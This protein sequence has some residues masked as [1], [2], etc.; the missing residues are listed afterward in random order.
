MLTLGKTED[1]NEDIKNLIRSAQA[2][3]QV[4]YCPYSDFR[5]GAA[6]LCV[7]K[8]IYSGMKELHL[9]IIFYDVF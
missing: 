2:A 3:R 5:V 4:A 8:T 7:D 9:I 1:A 6:V